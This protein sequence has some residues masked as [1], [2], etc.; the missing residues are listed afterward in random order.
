MCILYTNIVSVDKILYMAHRILHINVGM[1]T[2][3]KNHDV[4]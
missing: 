3:I 4:I 1:K 2:E